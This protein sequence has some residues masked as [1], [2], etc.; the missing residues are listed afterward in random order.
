[1]LFYAML[2]YAMLCYAMLCIK[3]W[4]WIAFFSSPSSSSLGG[5]LCKLIPAFSARATAVSLYHRSSSIFLLVRRNTMEHIEWCSKGRPK[6]GIFCYLVDRKDSML[7][8]TQNNKA[9]RCFWQLNNHAL[10]TINKCFIY[11]CMDKDWVVWKRLLSHEITLPD[12]PF[13]HKGQRW[14]SC[15]IKTLTKFSSFN[16][17]IDFPNAD[18]HVVCNPADVHHMRMMLCYSAQLQLM[19]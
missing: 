4:V 2:C 9:I 14:K 15:C 19:G 5:S 17:Y 3:V 18:M 16:V 10:R 12:Y 7:Y 13:V 1:M 6:R 11:G 8:M